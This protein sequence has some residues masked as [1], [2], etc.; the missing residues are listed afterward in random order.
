MMEEA[1]IYQKQIQDFHKKIEMLRKNEEELKV[2]EEHATE[3]LRCAE[4]NY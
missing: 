4:Q 1:G 3:V 2:R